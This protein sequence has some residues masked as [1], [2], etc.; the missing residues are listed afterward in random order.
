MHVSLCWLRLNFVEHG[1]TSATSGEHSLKVGIYWEKRLTA[2]QKRYT[3]RRDAGE[4]AGYDGRH[5]A[6]RIAHGGNY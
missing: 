4:G 2:A 5:T 1:Y 6:D 3:R